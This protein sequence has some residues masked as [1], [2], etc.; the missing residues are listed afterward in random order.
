MSKVRARALA[1]C[2]AGRWFPRYHG[3]YKNL[4]DAMDGVEYAG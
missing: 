2:F 4:F 3:L 1:I